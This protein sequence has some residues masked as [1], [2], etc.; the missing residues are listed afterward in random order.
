MTQP[1][2]VSMDV[3]DRAVDGRLFHTRGAAE[4]KARDAMSVL[5]LG[6]IS[7]FILD[8][9]SVSEGLWSTTSSASYDGCWCSRTL[10][11]NIAT[12]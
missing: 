12:L 1:R 9:R 7:K 6:S 2:N 8:D 5:V 3:A 10:N 11:V 4:L